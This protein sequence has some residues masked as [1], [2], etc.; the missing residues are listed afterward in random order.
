MRKPETAK[1]ICTPSSPFPNEEVRELRREQLG[2]GDLR[3]GQADVDMVH[4]HEK[5]REATEQIDPVKPPPAADTG[6]W[7]RRCHGSFCTKIELLRVLRC[8]DL[9]LLI[10]FDRIKAPQLTN[11]G[12]RHFYPPFR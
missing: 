7:A 12:L 1:N 2:I 3:E 8:E 6:N 5:N 10:R 4:Q 9:R 11:D